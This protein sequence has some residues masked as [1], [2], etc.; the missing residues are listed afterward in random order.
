MYRNGPKPSKDSLWDEVITEIPYTAAAQAYRTDPFFG[1]TAEFEVPAKQC[2]WIA[3]Q[4][5]PPIDEEAAIGFSE[6]VSQRRKKHKI[7]GK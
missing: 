6:N 5:M 2:E 4:P 7:G 3:E 1:S